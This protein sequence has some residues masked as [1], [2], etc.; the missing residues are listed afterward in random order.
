MS[1]FQK[2][3][4]KRIL[5]VLFCCL[6][7]I[8]GFISLNSF[9]L[10]E[11]GLIS[12]YA[13]NNVNYSPP[14]GNKSLH[15]GNIETRQFKDVYILYEPGYSK[16]TNDWYKTRKIQIN[17]K[18]LR[19]ENFSSRQKDEFRI[20]FLG[21]SFTFGIGVN[22][23]DRYTDI[24]EGKLNQK[25]FEVMTINAGIAGAGITDYKEFFLERGK[26]YEPDVIVASISSNDV[27]SRR[28]IDEARKNL[29]RNNESID[30]PLS[31]REQIYLNKNIINT[32]KTIY[33]K[34]NGSKL[35]KNLRTIKEK[36]GNTSLVV[37]GYLL[38]K[39]THKKSVKNWSKS[40]ENVF[41]KQKYYKFE[42][43]PS[44]LYRIP[45]DGHYN[46]LGHLWMAQNLEP[47]LID[48]LRKN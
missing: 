7:V 34:S 38:G 47:V 9:N 36:S 42:Y 5:I 41:Y 16:H 3:N 8:S 48:L 13:L 29:I 37:H 2:L 39:P 33:S 21:D 1:Y 10:N 31:P 46:K 24:I 32:K 25:G 45:Y 26:N 43:L 17:S 19:E 4:L 35:V 11:A 44:E 15:P 27:W 18:G 23:S 6:A 22:E 20:L 40:A 12:E 30:R 14:P 28:Q